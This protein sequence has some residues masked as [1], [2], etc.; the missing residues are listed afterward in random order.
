MNRDLIKRILKEETSP[1]EIRKGIDVAVKILKKSYPFVVG[2]EYSDSP[3]TWTYRIYINLEIDY[4]KSLK[5]YGLR[6]HP[7]IS[8]FVLN[9]IEDGER[10]SYPYSLMDYEEKKD[11]DRTQY[12]KI[13]ENLDEIYE[14]MIPFKFKMNVTNLASNQNDPKDLGVDNYIFVE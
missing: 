5:Y 8:K 14:E 13:Q 12:R 9:A 10:L 1:E 11:F 3:D 6:P 2:W 7:E 4:N